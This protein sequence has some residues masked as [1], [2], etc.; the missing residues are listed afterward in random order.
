VL[1]T[2]FTLSWSGLEEHETPSGSKQQFLYT[3]FVQSPEC[4]PG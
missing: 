1:E 4:D 3:N 2:D